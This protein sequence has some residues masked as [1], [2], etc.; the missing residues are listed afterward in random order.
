MSVELECGHV[1][2]QGERVYNYYDHFPVTL[3]EEDR[4]GWWDTIKDDGTRGPLLNGERM[5]SLETARQKG[6]YDATNDPCWVEVYSV[7]QG[8]GGPEEGGW[9]Y[10]VGNKILSLR[11]TYGEA[12]NVKENLLHLY[13][14]TGKRYSVVAG[15]DYE[16]HVTAT[17]GPAYFPESKPH[18][19]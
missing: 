18:Y 10:S 8:Y 16:V 4:D 2:E 13:P 12:Q 15:E 9:W 14:S 3:L 6:W 5:C 19:E 1:A 17:Q 7:G 11:S